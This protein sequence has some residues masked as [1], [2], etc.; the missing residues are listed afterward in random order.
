M[1]RIGFQI[2][3]SGFDASEYAPDTAVSARDDTRSETISL[4]REGHQGIREGIRLDFVDIWAV[5]T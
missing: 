2:G 4:I 5:R 1:M 3:A